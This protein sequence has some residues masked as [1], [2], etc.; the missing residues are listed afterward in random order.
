MTAVAR[1]REQ[2]TQLLGAW[3]TG[4]EG[5]FGKLIRWSNPSSKNTRRFAPDYDTEMLVS[6]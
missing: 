2:V 3:R 6:F 4:D 1:S 5:A